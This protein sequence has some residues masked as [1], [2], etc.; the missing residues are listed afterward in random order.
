MKKSIFPILL[1]VVAISSIS[2][3]DQIFYAKLDKSE[4][5][6]EVTAAVIKDFNDELLKVEYRALPVELIEEGWFV[7]YD[8][9]KLDNDYNTYG[10]SISGKD[11][12][13]HA[14]YDASGN[15]ISFIEKVKDVPLPRPVQ[16]SI[17]KNFPGWGVSGDHE[18]VTVNKKD[19]Q[20]KVYYRVLLTQDQEKKLVVY[21]GDGNLVKVGKEHK[22][23]F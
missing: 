19:D 11:I 8:P 14:T 4:V 21:N 6:S 17:G 5:P 18:I 9:N 13:G 7:N 3:Q 1:A 15:L 12:T 22:I 20:Q 16:K 2:A 23:L 10:V